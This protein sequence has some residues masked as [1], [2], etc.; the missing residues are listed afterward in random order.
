MSKGIQDHEKSVKEQTDSTM[1]QLGKVGNYDE[2]I[3]Q[4]KEKIDK[5]KIRQPSTF[6]MPELIHEALAVNPKSKEG[7]PFDRQTCLPYPLITYFECPFDKSAYELAHYADAVTSA[8][9][10]AA[11]MFHTSLPSPE[12]F[13]LKADFQS[14]AN[15][16]YISQYATQDIIREFAT[17]YVVAMFAFFKKGNNAERIR[18]TYEARRERFMYT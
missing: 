12:E 10:D 17:Q 4:I 13:A 11:I 7:R 8:F 2:L 6:K 5:T 16:S 3:Q 9:T 1:Q 18:A 15:F 14:I